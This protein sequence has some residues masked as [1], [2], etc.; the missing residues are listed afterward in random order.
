MSI[1]DSDE[2]VQ[3]ELSYTDYLSSPLYDLIIVLKRFIDFRATIDRMQEEVEKARSSIKRVLE[4]EIPCIGNIEERQELRE[5][6]LEVGGLLDFLSANMEKARDTG[7]LASKISSMEE[8]NKEY[9][10]LLKTATRSAAR[11]ADIEDLIKRTSEEIP[12]ENFKVGHYREIEEK[13]TEFL[14]GKIDLDMYLGSLEEIW[15]RIS[16]S[17]DQFEGMISMENES[18]VEAT[19]AAALIGEAY[20][21]WDDAFD[22]LSQDDPERV[23]MGL[24]MSENANRKLVIVQHLKKKMEK[25]AEAVDLKGLIA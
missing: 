22:Y 21:Q 5:M 19:T 9:L 10:Q 24:K 3:P 14:E 8:I 4:E 20:D 23:E 11:A 15:A 12:N 25:K 6:L 1:D 17:R 2:I 7:S 13:A 16:Q 18:S